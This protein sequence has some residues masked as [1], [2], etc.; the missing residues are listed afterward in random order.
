M[1]FGVER[2]E[3]GIEGAELQGQLVV[4]HDGHDVAGLHGAAFLDVKRD[5]G[6]ADA[7]AGRDHVAALDP[8]EYGLKMVF[9]SARTMN[10][11]ARAG[12]TRL[13]GRR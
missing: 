8:A 9:G 5:D 10:S 7:G 11:P 2:L 4:D 6:A 12:A 13:V 1:E 3:A